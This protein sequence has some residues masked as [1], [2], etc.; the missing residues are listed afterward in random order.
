MDLR[1]QLLALVAPTALGDELAPGVVLEDASTE[2]GLRLT[3]VSEG[4]RVHVEVMPPAPDRPYACR[5]DRWALSYRGGA[6][7]DPL[8]ALRVTRAV[9]DRVAANEASVRLT[10]TDTDDA[11][12]R[13]RE[14]TV[15]RILEP[16]A[17]FSTLSPY[18]GCLIGCR[19]CYAQ[20]RLVP[21][22]RLLG[23]ADVPWG[24]WV[25]A[26]INAAEVLADE[27]RDREPAPIKLCPIVSDPYHAIERKLRL[28]RAC[29]QTIADV[30]P[31]T[32]VLLLTR[33]DAILDDLDLLTRLPNLYA[34][35]SLPSADAEVLAHFEPRAA[36]A[37]RRAQVLTVLAAAG[38][39]TIA[40]VQPQ[41]P[42]SLD[43][44]VALLAGSVQ[45]VSLDVL[46]GVENAAEQFADAR[47]SHAATDAWQRERLAALRT[48]LQ[49]AGVAV[50][51]GE[52]PPGLTG[53]DRTSD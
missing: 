49:A 2:L 27:L 26:R 51:P 29:L 46:R 5:T 38:I 15:D 1:A 44:H 14:V 13:I 28:T 24:S 39:H 34:G 48:R 31:D 53:P 42:G 33:S 40:V 20:S 6:D 12:M 43:D 11:D 18:V 30:A 50:W 21:L 7:L 16:N 9:A 23:H 8:L 32:P 4:T 52:L 19:F 47:W 3:V 22:R 45:S 10:D 41:L 17:G 36:P 37:Q 25:D 35:M